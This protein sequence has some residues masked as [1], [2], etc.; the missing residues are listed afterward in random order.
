ME[1]EIGELDFV[2]EFEFGE[3]ELDIVEVFPELEALEITP[4]LEEQN[5]K[6]SKY[7]YSDVIVKAIE[8]EDLEITPQKE[9]QLKTG[10]Y[11]NVKVLG[12]ENLAPENIKSGVTIFN[13]EGTHPDAEYFD[14]L[15]SL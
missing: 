8:T 3:L 4:T 1:E 5:L 14:N 12:D 11:R 10:V 7:G 6:S 2:K 15:L 13:V 9:E